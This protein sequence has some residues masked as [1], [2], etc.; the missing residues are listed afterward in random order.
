[1]AI[2]RRSNSTL[3]R[4]RS[5]GIILLRPSE[6]FDHTLLSIPGLHMAEACLDNRLLRAVI[7]PDAFVGSAGGL[8]RLRVFG[9]RETP[10]LFGN[11]RPVYAIGNGGK[12]RLVDCY[13]PNCRANNGQ[14]IGDRAYRCE[15]C[16]TEWSAVNHRPAEVFLS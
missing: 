11:R 16:S 4:V 6:R 8:I 7:V 14:P 9:Q 12:F 13:C 5:T 1:M 15:V 3:P 10:N 2:R